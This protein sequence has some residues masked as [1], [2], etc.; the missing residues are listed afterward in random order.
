MTVSSASAARTTYPN[1]AEHFNLQASKYN[2]GVEKVRWTGPQIL[3]QQLIKSGFNGPVK[4]L[5]FGTGRGNVAKVLKEKFNP[6]NVKGY[7]VSA[8]MVR[9]AN[10]DGHNDLTL[11]GGVRDLAEENENEY[12]LFTSCGVLDFLTPEDTEALSAQASR[13]L[14]PGGYFAVTYEPRGTSFPGIQTLQHDPKVLRSQF[15]SKGGRVLVQA[16]VGGLYDNFGV[17]TPHEKPRVENHILIGKY[18]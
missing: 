15:E 1:V 3:V 14:K 9:H 7:D 10:L 8:E 16:S 17:K 13:V 6:V 12:H 11:K 5:D 2:I 18:L 4:G